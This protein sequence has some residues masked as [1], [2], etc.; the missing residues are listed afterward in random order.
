MVCDTP[1]YVMPKA[2]TEKVPVPC[3]RCPVCKRKRASSWAFRLRQHERRCPAHF[4]TFTYD[5]DHVPISNNG[6]MTLNKRDVQLYFKRLR[7]L[8]GKSVSIKYYLV[9]EYGGKTHRPHYHAIIFGVSDTEDYFRAWHID[10]SPI[11]TVHVGGVSAASVAY[12]LKYI[13]KPPS[14]IFHRN[15]DRIRE[16]SLM[17]KGLGADYLSPAVESYHR[18][19][20][21]RLYV[22]QDAYK[23]SM[24]R[25]YRHK[26]WS[27]SERRS[28]ALRI[29]AQVESVDLDVASSERYARYYSFNR[30]YEFH[31]TA[32]L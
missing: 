6:F 17:S 23:V 14:P 9:G 4:V 32:K 2:G 15:D 7:K 31:D 22:T 1:F 10:G 30:N 16:F 8:C 21:L 26:L 18:S 13:S 12:T 24:P 29:A 28:Q 5:T 27:E 25:Y 3:G 20:D 11:G 19:D